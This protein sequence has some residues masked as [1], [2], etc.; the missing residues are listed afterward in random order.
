MQYRIA[1]AHRPDRTFRFR[2]S[3]RLHLARRRINFITLR[4]LI[5]LGNGLKRQKRWQHNQ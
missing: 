5:A 4:N 2:Y 3:R 1:Q